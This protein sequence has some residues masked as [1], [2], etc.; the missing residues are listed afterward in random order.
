MAKEPANHPFLHGKYQGPKFADAAGFLFLSSKGK[1]LLL[2]RAG[3]S[4][5]SGRWG[6]AGGWMEPGEAPMQTAVRESMEELGKLPRYLKLLQMVKLHWR[7]T[8]YITWVVSCPIEFR[9]S[10]L[11][12]KEHSQWRWASPEEVQSGKYLLHDGFRETLEKAAP[13][14]LE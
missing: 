5:W 10:K 1:M 3:G 8:L 4:D 14:F 13:Y 7:G 12:K 11:D 2:K 6:S 9:P